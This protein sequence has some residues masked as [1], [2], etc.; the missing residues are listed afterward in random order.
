[1]TLK[2]NEDPLTL[3]NTIKLKIRHNAPCSL[4]EK[5]C[6][7]FANAKNDNEYCLLFFDDNGNIEASPLTSKFIDKT[8]VTPSSTQTPT[9]P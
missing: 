1:M 5:N 7:I 3:G 2:T 8:E 6:N 9:T 4:E